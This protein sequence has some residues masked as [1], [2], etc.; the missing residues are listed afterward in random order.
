TGLTLPN[1]FPEDAEALN[2]SNKGYMVGGGGEEQAQNF[3]RKNF[4]GTAFWKADLRT[5][6]DGRAQAHFP[7]PDN[8]TRFRLVAV[9][10]AGADRFGNAESSFEVNKPLMLEPALPSFATIGDKLIARAVLRNSSTSSGEA[11][12]TLRLDD[13]TEPATPL[14]R[15]LTIEPNASAAIDFPVEFK[16][17][18]VAHWIWSA[19]LNAGV[20]PL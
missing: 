4:L 1:L 8:L 19:R 5:G 7:A 20:M 6:A 17:P 16:N 11:E 9:V 15:R 12:V 18:G 2:Y 14:V 3:L 10:N 13:K